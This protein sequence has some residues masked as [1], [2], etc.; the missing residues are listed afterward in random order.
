[1]CKINLGIK[2]N[3]KEINMDLVNY[4]SGAF[5]SLSILSRFKKNLITLKNRPKQRSRASDEDNSH[6]LVGN[7]ISLPT[8]DA[9]LPVD[10]SIVG[11]FCKDA[12]KTFISKA[13]TQQSLHKNFVEEFNEPSALIGK[14]TFNQVEREFI[15]PTAIYTFGIDIRDLVFQR[16]QGHRVIV[17]ISGSAGCIL[18]FSMCTPEEAE[19]NPLLFFKKMYV[20]NVPSEVMF[21]LR[22]TGTIY[23]QFSP[24]DYNENG[25]FAVSVHA[26]EAFGLGGELLEKIMAG[27]GSIPILTEPAPSVVTELM[28]KN[29][30]CYKMATAVYLGATDPR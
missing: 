29:P 19:M 30:E 16:H 5:D 17:G 9:R 1:M 28:Q 25:F 21:V 15:D 24:V 23:H 8:G 7:H 14:P 6:V 18:R 13:F 2:L 10:I 20:V 27:E 12:T 4:L 3:H 11:E 26:N 22:F